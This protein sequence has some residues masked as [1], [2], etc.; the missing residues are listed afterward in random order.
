M[1]ASVIQPVPMVPNVMAMMGRIEWLL[2]AKWVRDLCWL[3][4]I[5]AGDDRATENK[6]QITR[7]MY[8]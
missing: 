3:G 2:R 4:R 5:V 1:N 8:N 6:K 7:N